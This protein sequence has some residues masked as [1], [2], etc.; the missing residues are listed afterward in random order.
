MR[1]HSARFVAA[2]ALVL[3]IAGS[4]HAQQGA[5][6]GEWRYYGGDAGNSKYSPLDQIDAKNVKELEI[7]WRWKAEN[8]G[9]TP[10][11][12]WEVTPLMIGGVLYFTAGSRRAV[13]AVDAATGETLWMYRL[14]EGERGDRAPRKQ[15]RGLAYW[16]DGQADARI[17]LITPGYQLVALD[18]KTGRPIPTFGKDGI[19]ELTEGL[20]REV[21]KP[22]QIG[23][24]S[25]A[26]VVRDVVV[27]GAAMIAGTAPPSK[28]HVPGYVRG[29][30]VRTGRK[31]WTFKTIPQPGEFGHETWEGDSWKYTGNT[32]A[33]A[34]L[35]GD[36]EL[37][38]VYL[39]VETPTGDFY[40]G[41]RLGDNLFG[42]SLV[43]LD[44]RTG[45]RIWHFQIVHHDIWDWEPSSPPILADITVAGRKIKAV[46]L[47]TKHGF[48]F[49][50]DR[51][52][53]T[54]VWP[55]EERPVPQSDVPGE[56]TSPTQP[57][58]TKPAP[59]ERQGVTVDDLID[60]TPELRAEAIAIFK[61]YKTSTN[62]FLPPIVP[63]TDGKLAALWLPNHIGGAN[64]PGG[65]LD[66]ETGI[67]YVSSLTNEDAVAVQKGD[68]K[69]TDMAYVAALGAHAGAPAGAAQTAAPPAAGEA[70]RRPSFGPRGLPLVRPPWGRITAIDLNTGDHVWMIANGDAPDIVKNNPALKGLNLDLSKAGKPERSPLM[71]TKTLL[72]GADG[73]GLF[74]SGPG[75]GGP[76]FR[77][78]DKKTGAIVHEMKLPAST[79]GIPMTYMVDDRQYI[80]VAI[81]ARGVPAELVA[82]AVP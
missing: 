82:L 18:A 33:W 71:V 63:G 9:P 36:E 23:S 42:D 52:N 72:F 76:M 64:W 69:R 6:N 7:V 11:Y 12:N 14:D 37:G 59:F 35:A 43:C 47:V 3:A 4:S 16:T 65:A 17:L 29:F 34:P 73:S 50:F 53:G 27:V 25:P 62:P 38:Y 79:T 10:D 55:I 45:K 75:S 31:I 44:A 49:V 81:G 22:G 2:S 20:D 32:A 41:H 51:V 8:F 70:S 15:N 60:F 48:T 13:V 67:M 68:P 78:I 66:P 21:V 77:A 80:V 5:A 39:P 1:P 61:Q 57:F 28:A 19:V 56:R 24:S 40:G 30:D 54:P 74:S 46:A 58:P 26:I